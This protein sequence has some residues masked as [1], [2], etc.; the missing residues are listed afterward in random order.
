MYLWL[1]LYM[2]AYISSPSGCAVPCA[3]TEAVEEI[4]SGKGRHQALFWGSS[5][6]SSYTLGSPGLRHVPP[7]TLYSVVVYTIC[8]SCQEPPK[9]VF[10]FCDGVLEML[11]QYCS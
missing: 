4:R 8:S 3:N 1:H 2:F 5:V 9:C 10:C 6:A 11:L 7:S